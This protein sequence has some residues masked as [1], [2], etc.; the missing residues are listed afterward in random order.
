M[1]FPFK[2]ILVNRKSTEAKH[3]VKCVPTGGMCDISVGSHKHIHTNPSHVTNNR[4]I[5]TCQ[6]YMNYTCQRPQGKCT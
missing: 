1:H 6:K 2:Y 5:E 4:S 3:K